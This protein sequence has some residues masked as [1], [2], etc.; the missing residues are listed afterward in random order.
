MSKAF[1]SID[2]QGHAGKSDVW[3]TPIE[4]IE[5]MGKFD[6]DPCGYPGHQTASELIC[7]P[8]DGLKAK[9]SGKIWLNPPYSNAEPWLNKLAEHG[10][11]M[12]LIF[13]RTGTNYIQRILRAA[14]YVVFVRGRISFINPKDMEKRTNAGADSML[15]CFGCAPQD[16]SI[17]VR[18]S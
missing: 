8:D 16:K 2:P 9:W 11:G 5:R 3:L 15:I 4:L 10:Y 1:T 14:D 17:G 18:L 12:G 7:L 6:M 13:T